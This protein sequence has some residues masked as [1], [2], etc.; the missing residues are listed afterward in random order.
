[1]AGAAQRGGARGG[2]WRGGH[3]RVEARRRRLSCGT[4]RRKPDERWCRRYG[5][6]AGRREPYSAANSNM[7]H[8]T[9]HNGRIH[10]RVW[11][12]CHRQTIIVDSPVLRPTC[13]LE[14]QI[15]R[16]L[17]QLKLM[18]ISIHRMTQRMCQL[19]QFTLNVA[20]SLSFKLFQHF[21]QQ[22]KQIKIS[23]LALQ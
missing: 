5:G 14:I 6:A 4:P 3:A 8:I 13:Q 9:S 20:Q 10:D 11:W 1:M 16:N 19:K 15:L 22:L 21:S 12:L 7:L 17:Q 2:S 18:Q 23:V